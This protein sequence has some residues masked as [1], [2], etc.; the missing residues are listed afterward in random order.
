MSLTMSIL[1]EEEL[2]TRRDT[3]PA[4]LRSLSSAG[5]GSHALLVER[6]L[7]HLAT[8]QL[9]IAEKPAT[10]RGRSFGTPRLR[11]S[12]G[13]GKLQDLKGSCG[14]YTGRVAWLEQTV[15][16][17]HAENKHANELQQQLP[18]WVNDALHQPAEQGNK[19]HYHLDVP[20]Y[21]QSIDQKVRIVHCE[22]TVNVCLDA[23]RRQQA[24]RCAR[25][26][27]DGM[28]FQA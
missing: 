18:D 28:C 21:A 4:M 5:G 11:D 10:A 19:F 20:P 2:A 6:P 17:L 7:P 26:C 25:A 1:R 24:N 27:W 15:S 22:S 16:D 14:T 3:A 12:E 13:N 8:H 23:D 9:T